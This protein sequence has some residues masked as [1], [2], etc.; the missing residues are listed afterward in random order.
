MS[1]N[2]THRD[3]LR[4]WG[5][6]MSYFTGKLEGYL[7]FKEIPY[8]RVAMTPWHF[9]RVVPRKTGAMQMPAVE[10]ADG[11]WLTDTTPIIAWLEARH[12]EPAVIP[13]DPL[14]AFVSRLLEDYADEWLWRPAMHFRWSYAQGR[15][16]VADQLVRE[17]FSRVPLPA[18]WKRWHLQRRQRRIFVRGDGVNA[19]TRDHVEGGYLRALEHLE[20]ILAQRPFLLGARPSLADFGYFGPMFRHFGC[21]P[22]PVAIMRNRAPR[23]YAWVA[24]VWNARSSELRG[25]LEAG[26][27][28]DW[29]SIL[30]E[31]G[32]THLEHLAANAEAHRDG[33]ER[34]DAS[35]QGV[36]YRNLPSSRYRVWC[37][38]QLRSH[39]EALPDPDGARALLTRHGCWE[40]LWR[41]KALASGHD[42]KGEAPFAAGLRVYPT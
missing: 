37:L 1:G 20:A 10:L 19:A 29:G 5:S 36:R 22:T 11:R 14:Q 28:E 35:F 25:G 7:R 26:I 34:F 4:V 2:A 42:P 6:E 18:A 13:E 8:E 23:V 17:L 39:F 31:I 21:D 12:P 16:L 33:R 41:V 24:R 9:S 40:P 38:E 32:A 27:P 3:R 30:D 15:R